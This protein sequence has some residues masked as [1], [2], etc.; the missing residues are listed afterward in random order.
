MAAEVALA[1]VVVRVVAAGAK[2]PQAATRAAT[3]AREVASFRR[4][5]A[6]VW[7]TQARHVMMATSGNSI[8]A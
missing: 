5:V 6:M 3:E 8:A 7:S 2:A 1:A 4:P